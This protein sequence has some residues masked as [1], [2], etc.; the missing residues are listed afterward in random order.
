MKKSLLAAALA[1]LI[2]VAC[3]GAEN[4]PAESS[5]QPQTNAEAQKGGELNI[6][7]WSDY[8]DPAT[9]AAFEKADNIKVRYDYYDSNEALEAKILTGKSGYDL[10]APSISN[11]GRQIKAGAYQEIDK[12]KIPNYGNIDP[13]LLKM[14]E[15]VDPGNK[16]AVP[17]FWG[18]NTLAINKDMV[19]KVLGTDK[20]P[21]NE[22]DLVFDPTYT[23]KLKSC[24]ISYFDS[25]IEQIPLALN[26][27]GKDPNSE[28]P[29][30]IKAAVEMMKK[31]RPDIKRFTSSGYI[32]DMAAG[33]L[34]VAIGYGGDLNIAKTRAKEAGNGINIQVLTPASGVGIWVDSF[35]IPRD[36]QNITNAHKYINY[37]LDPEVAAKNGNFVT[38][39]PASLPARKL[40][41]PQYANDN[42]IFPSKEVMEKSFVV[43]PKSSDASK[44]SVRLWQGLKAGQ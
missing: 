6:Y 40:M 21:E 16:Y 7:N 1:S 41:E 34:C 43:S 10:V 33:N 25:A 37:T 30:D 19:T 29:D 38:Y 22:W 15:T 23:T 26:Y 5:S 35:M 2:L 12:S 17:Y 42:S 28:N 36:A 20:L 4:K 11:V 9:L 44:L 3:G 24:G 14:M 27:L 39:A 8:V 32:D 31:V 13:E 18:M